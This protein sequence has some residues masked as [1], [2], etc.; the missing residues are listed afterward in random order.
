MRIA[1]VSPYSWTYPGGVTRHIEALAERFIEEGHDVRVL[2]PYDPA[3]TFAA[4]LHRG[5]RPQPLQA[6][7]YLVSLGRTIGF[8]ANGAVSNLSITPYAVA[9]MQRELRTGGYDVV[10]IHEPVAPL[11]GWLAADSTRLPLVGTFHSYSDSRISN[12]IANLFGARRVLNHLHVRIAVSEAAAWTARRFFGGH[13]RVIPNGVHVDPQLA[14]PAAATSSADRLRIVFVGQAVERKGLPLL[15][16]AF[17]ALREHIPAELTVIGPTQQELAPLMLDDRGV[18]VLGKVD[19]AR[20]QLELEHADLLCAPSLRGESFDMVLT[21]AFAAGTPVIA[22]DIAGYRDVV[23]DG[24]DGLLVPPG[25]AQALAEVLRDLWDEPA[26]R[27]EMALAAVRDVQRFAWPRVASEVMDSYADA[28]ATPAPEGRVQRAAVRIGARPADLKPHAPARRLPSLEPPLTGGRSP[29]V[30][31]AR[32]A[33]L[34]IV[35]LGGLL[36]AWLALQKIGVG[37]VTTAL[38]NSSPAFVL[39]GLGIMCSAMVLRGFSWYAILRAALPRARIRIS[40]AMQGTF[41]GVLMSSTLPARLGEPSRALVV[42]RRTGRPRE[43]LPVV[44][45]TLVSQ[46]MLNLVALAILGAVMFSSVDL[47][48]GHQDALLVAALAPL[49]LLV[50]VLLAPVL[51]RHGSLESR[52]GRVHTVVGQIR[53]ALTRVRAGLAVF[54]R[55]KLGAAAAAAQLA[56]WGLQ[57]LACYVLLV[58]LGLNRQAGIAAAAAV[59]FA[60]N[61]TAVLPATPA[62]VGVFQAAC[63]AVLH[64][65]WHVGFGAGVAYGVIL[66]AVEVSSALLMG[67]PALLKEGMSWREVR[68]RAMNAAPVKLPARPQR[69]GS[70]RG[71]GPVKA[72]S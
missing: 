26:R 15:L 2:A 57:W 63:A 65:G 36:L 20:K 56:A 30:R 62:N 19:D 42:A 50:I 46:T 44:L 4:G 27:A 3:D 5:A 47:F 14:V 59:L 23:R 64:T 16:N 68:L 67:M 39:L 40:D 34:A 37:N 24:V 61:I 51:L 32:R 70:R 72:K 52:F 7:D 55:P 13:Y 29:L 41:I 54:R 45:G 71:S 35:S 21:E 22:S 18:R 6:P 25:D 11:L 43:N 60:V 1:L 53:A 10:H 28:I 38:I 12:G 31:F 58:A 48:S 69:S 49:T 9:T 33:S 17:E 8:K 66:Q